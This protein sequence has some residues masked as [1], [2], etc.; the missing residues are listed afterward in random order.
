MAKLAVQRWQEV[1]RVR[2][3]A[4]F[5][6]IWRVFPELSG[7][8]PWK[9]QTTAL[10]TMNFQGGQGPGSCASRDGGASTHEK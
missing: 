8:L 10:V 4:A 9:L 2:R 3:A 5:E 1:D 7:Q 6:Q